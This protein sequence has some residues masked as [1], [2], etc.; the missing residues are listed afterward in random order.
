M[1]PFEG[2]S[3]VRAGQKHSQE[4]FLGA[5][6]QSVGAVRS[7]TFRDY[8]MF[9]SGVLPFSVLFTRVLFVYNARN[10]VGIDVQRGS[11]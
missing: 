7:R 2:L 5:A 4:T 10:R 3:T 1:R 8:L 6:A 9:N 11:P